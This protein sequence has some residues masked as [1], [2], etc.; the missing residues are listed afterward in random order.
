M[1]SE[2]AEVSTLAEAYTVLGLDRAP[3]AV[4]LKR[5]F[6]RKARKVHP[7]KRPAG[8]KALAE[9]EFR[10]LVQA[11]E[12]VER[13]VILKLPVAGAGQA[14]GQEGA[15][16]ATSN[17]TEP[18]TAVPEEPA[19]G[20]HWAKPSRGSEVRRRSRNHPQ[21]KGG[22]SSSSS[23]SQGGTQSSWSQQPTQ[24]QEQPTQS[25]QSRRQAHNWE[26]EL[27]SSDSD[28][29]DADV[30]DVG[31]GVEVR[32]VRVRVETGWRSERVASDEE[33]F[34]EEPPEPVEKIVVEE[35]EKK[36]SVSREVK[37]KSRCRFAVCVLM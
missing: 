27:F 21:N 29:S 35:S 23:W 1:S 2:L 5:A 24:S 25:Q 8:E 20:G 11:A 6:R 36:V 19:L 26:E 17:A 18:R 13:V 22:G 4:S 33:G 10:R 34:L 9:T 37:N 32:A 28:G 15:A 16:A 31:N 30:A 7:D 3:D 12:L 14:G